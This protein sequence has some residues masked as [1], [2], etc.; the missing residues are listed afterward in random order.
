M[1]FCGRFFV[2]VVIFLGCRFLLLR[3]LCCWCIVVFCDMVGLVF[4]VLFW[5]SGLCVG[6]CFCFVWDGMW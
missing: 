1:K 6:V 4:L 2:K 5:C 3:S